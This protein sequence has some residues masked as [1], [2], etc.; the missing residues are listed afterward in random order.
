[1]LRTSDDPSV[2]VTRHRL[3]SGI[4]DERRALGQAFLERIIGEFFHFCDA[5]QLAKPSSGHRDVQEYEMRFVRLMPEPLAHALPYA[6]SAEDFRRCRQAG[7][8]SV[9]ATLGRRTVGDGK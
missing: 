8:H 1:M 4:A 9:E 5:R 6:M 3:G 7:V 2:G